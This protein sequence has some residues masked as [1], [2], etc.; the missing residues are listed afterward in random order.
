[1]KLT[2]NLLFQADTTNIHKIYMGQKL[3]RFQSLQQALLHGQD[4]ESA[5]G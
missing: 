4:G 1:M 5:A 2:V 3:C